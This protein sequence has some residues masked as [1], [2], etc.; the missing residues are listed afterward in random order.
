MEATGDNWKYNYTANG[1]TTNIVDLLKD[2]SAW[3][4]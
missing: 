1:L 3:S 2:V 4:Q